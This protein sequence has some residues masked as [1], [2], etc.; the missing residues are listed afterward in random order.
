MCQERKTFSN[1]KETKKGKEKEKQL[2][3]APMLFY[4]DLHTSFSPLSNLY[5]ILL[6]IPI[7]IPI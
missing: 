4:L 5:F 7:Q 2:G 1:T 3:K 6:Y